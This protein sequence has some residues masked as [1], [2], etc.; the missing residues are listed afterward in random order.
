MKEHTTQYQKEKPKNKYGNLCFGIN[1][2]FF[3]LLTEFF[4]RRLICVNVM[5]KWNEKKRNIIKTT[6]PIQRFN[7]KNKFISSIC[8]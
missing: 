1:L 8:K 4:F 5:Q 6:G 3:M 2:L 7:K